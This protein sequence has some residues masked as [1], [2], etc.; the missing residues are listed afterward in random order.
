MEEIE[1]RR[2][3]TR[4]RE[5]EEGF[6][7]IGRFNSINR[8]GRSELVTERGELVEERGE[9]AQV[10]VRGPIR[11]SSDVVRRRRGR[12]QRSAAS[13]EPGVVSWWRSMASQLQWR[14]EDRS[15]GRRM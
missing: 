10:A 3:D 6:V 12:G 11:Q 13:C 4:A 5:D 15:A 9:P 1:R 8:T 7:I 14:R 2:R